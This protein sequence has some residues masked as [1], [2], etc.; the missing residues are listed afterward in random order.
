MFLKNSRYAKVRQ[1]SVNLSKHRQVQAV[2]LRHLPPTSGSPQVVKA[3]DRLDYYAQRVYRDPTQF[4]HV[5]DANT[6]L[7]A[8]DLVSTMGRVIEVP[9]Q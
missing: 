3:N 2:T 1:V 9:E 7:E 6:D 4:W 5:A 8:N